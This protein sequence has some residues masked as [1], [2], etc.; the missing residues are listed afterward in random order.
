MLCAFW[1]AFRVKSERE[2]Y[3]KAKMHQIERRLH[4]IAFGNEPNRTSI[5]NVLPFKRPV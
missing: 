2:Q 4:R 1:D 3:G 5:E